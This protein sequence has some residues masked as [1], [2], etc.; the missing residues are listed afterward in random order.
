M[1][2]ST[3]GLAA[4]FVVQPPSYALIASTV[5]RSSSVRAQFEMPKF[6]WDSNEWKWPWDQQDEAP[7]LP[8]PPPPPPRQKIDLVSQV[9]TTVPPT[10]PSPPPVLSP[11]MRSHLFTDEASALQPLLEE[12]IFVPEWI[13]V[14]RDLGV[15]AVEASAEAATLGTLQARVAEVEA[16]QARRH[17]L[18]ECL[19]LNAQRSVAD[20]RMALLSDAAAIAPGKA[21]PADAAT[22]VRVQQHFP[23][24][25]ARQ[26]LAY[27]SDAAPSNSPEVNGRFDRVQAAKLYMGC[28]QFGYFLAQVFRGQAHLEDDSVLSPVEAQQMV[29]AIQQTTRCMKSEAAWVV[30]SRRAGAFFAIPK[31]ETDEQGADGKGADGA[32]EESAESASLGYE[33]LREF[34][35]QVQVVASAQQEEFFAAP[36][37]RDLT[38]EGTGSDGAGSDGSKGADAVSEPSV[39]S[40][41]PM[42]SFIGFNA[43]GLQAALAEGCLFGWHLWGAEAQARGELLACGAD[44]A[45]EALLTPPA[46]VPGE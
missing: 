9:F 14:V 42:A 17:A 13:R 44:G 38:A 33:A 32:A 12:A 45:V 1:L 41:L 37:P 7:E 8:P 34:T 36:P 28:V 31:Q 2:S 22:L 23:G 46:V 5:S 25:S 29:A 30:A 35:T 20:E 16:L 40:E 3:T 18:Q 24:Q 11:P 4:A 26:V 15:Q 39:P 21:L 10:A 19:L 43:A 6:P 27:V